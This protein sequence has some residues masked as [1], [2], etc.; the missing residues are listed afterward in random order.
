M[1]VCVLALSTA[2]TLQL[3]SCLH[4]PASSQPAAGSW[5]GLYGLVVCEAGQGAW[6]RLPLRLPPATS[7]SK[8]PQQA[9]NGLPTC[10]LG[11]NGGQAQVSWVGRRS[12][13][14]PLSASSVCSHLCGEPEALGQRQIDFTQNFT[15]QPLIFVYCGEKQLRS[16]AKSPPCFLT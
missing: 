2:F 11:L 12:P 7:S 6:P 16:C 10:W 9:K 1:C 3:R 14:V 8:F 15:F 4:L 5:Q 13:H